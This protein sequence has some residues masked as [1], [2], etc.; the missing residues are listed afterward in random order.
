EGHRAGDLERHFRRVDVVVRTVVQNRFHAR[1][2]ITGDDAALERF[3]DALFGRLDELARNRTADDVV[4]EFESTARKRLEL[5]L[6]V[7]ILALTAR[8]ANELAFGFR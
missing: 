7:A 5:H 4:D 8:L 3:F 6:D 2:R 1:H